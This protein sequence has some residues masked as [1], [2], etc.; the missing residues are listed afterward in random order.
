MPTKNEL[1][2]LKKDWST[3]QGFPLKWSPRIQAFF[4]IFMPIQTTW[5]KLSLARLGHHAFIISWS[6]RC[7]SCSSLPSSSREYVSAHMRIYNNHSSASFFFHCKLILYSS[8]AEQ[9]VPFFF[10]VW[11]NQDFLLHVCN[12]VEKQ[13]IFF[14]Q[15][16][17]VKYSG[18]TTLVCLFCA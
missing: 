2:R 1:I 16:Y 7:K 3:C 11:K 13:I 15:A 9:C 6:L 12:S 17:T 18:T 14:I 4:R 5:K 8:W 10:H